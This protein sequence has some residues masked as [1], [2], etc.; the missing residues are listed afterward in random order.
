[1]LTKPTIVFIGA[2]CGLVF[3]LVSIHNS[4][5]LNNQLMEKLVETEV[6]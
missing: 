4:R 2:A 1:M 3:L 5:S 6:R